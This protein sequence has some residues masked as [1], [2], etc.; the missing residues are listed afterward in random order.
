MHIHVA[1]RCVG[2]SSASLSTGPEKNSN[3]NSRFHKKKKWLG[4]HRCVDV[5]SSSSVLLYPLYDSVHLLI[6]FEL[7]PPALVEQHDSR[8]SLDPKLIA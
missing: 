7:D 3:R 5:V 8:V 2:P 4:I 1:I 6:S